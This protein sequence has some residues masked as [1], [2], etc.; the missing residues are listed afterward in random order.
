MARA[1]RATVRGLTGR[2]ILV[3]PMRQAT[4]RTRDA[5]PRQLPTDHDYAG[6]PSGPIRGYQSDQPSTLPFDRRLLCS[7][8]AATARRID[9]D[10]GTIDRSFH[11]R[12]RRSPWASGPLRISA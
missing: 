9:E 8:F 2:R 11:I 12:S 3:T 7:P 6:A 10:V 4:G 1:G 5:S